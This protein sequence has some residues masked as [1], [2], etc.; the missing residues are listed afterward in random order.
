MKIHENKTNTCKRQENKGKGTEN[1]LGYHRKIVGFIVGFIV[2]SRNGRR[3][4][5]FLPHGLEL[6]IQPKAP[7]D[8]LYGTFFLSD[9]CRSKS[10]PTAPPGRFTGARNTNDDSPLWAESVQEELCKHIIAGHHDAHP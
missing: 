5:P 7:E 2:L 6:R 4:Q 8:P 1:H 10:H 9:F 3:S